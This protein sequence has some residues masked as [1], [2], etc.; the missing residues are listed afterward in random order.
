[1]DKETEQKYVEAGTIAKQARDYGKDLIKVGANLKDVLESIENKI[2]ELGGGCAFP[3]QI[4]VNQIAAHYCAD[5]DEETVFETGDMCK[6]DLGVEIDGYI[7]DTAVTVY[8]GDDENMKLLS[9]ASKAALNA[10]LNL[11]KPG[12]K[13]KELGSAISKE[14]ESRGFQPIRNLSGHGLD[15]YVIHTKPTIPNYDNGDNTTLKEGDVIAIEPFA[16]NGV[17]LIYETES[18]NIFSEISSKPIRSMYAREVLKLVKEFKG[19]PFTTRQISRKLGMGKTRLGINELLKAGIIRGYPPLPE[20]KGG[21]VSQHE[22][23]IIV[24]DE[25]IVTTR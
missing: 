8:L 6:L 25:P 21:M 1:M 18:S 3:P 15:R 13:L 14:I 23:T 16:T 19:L 9:D 7:A 5:P 12:V 4:S 20:Q 2:I 22:H 17:G 11:V 10:A 24:K